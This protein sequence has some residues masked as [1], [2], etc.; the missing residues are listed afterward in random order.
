[1]AVL[2]DAPVARVIGHRFPKIFRKHEDSERFNMKFG[3]VRRDLLE[4]GVLAAELTAISVRESNQNFFPFMGLQRIIQRGAAFAGRVISE[5]SEIP[6]CR[7][8][9]R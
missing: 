3:V 8:C 6:H 1:M 4:S 9:L 5:L 2:G 7:P